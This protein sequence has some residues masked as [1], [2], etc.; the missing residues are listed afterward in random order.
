[1][2]LSVIIVNYRSWTSLATTLASLLD[3]T[4]AQPASFEII[5][6]DNDS[7]DGQLEEFQTRFP[8]VRFELAPGNH[9]FA[10]ACNIGVAA[11]SGQLLLFLN[12]DVRGRPEDLARLVAEKDAHGQYAIL[13]ACQTDSRNRPRKA[14]DSF[15]GL[16]TSVPAI[17]ALLRLLRPAAHP[18][19]R[20]AEG[21]SPVPVAL[22]WV[23]GSALLIS[24]TDLERLGGWNESFW[25]YYEDVD[26]CLRASRLG[27]RAAC[28][29]AV[30]VGHDHGGAS[31]R[32]E[33][34]SILTRT[35]VIIS[36]HVYVQN[37]FTGPYRI[38][39]HATLIIRET[40]GLALL[41]ALNLL[42]LSQLT[43]LR[44]RSGV[45]AGLLAHW[46]SALRRGSWQSPRAPA[47]D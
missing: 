24:R 26:L 41:A 14:G 35:E 40:A 12:P 43:A 32:D 34:T 6:V 3:D 1:M 39:F 20:L 4:G 21:S 42:T 13:T 7:A 2:R 9:G 29:T 37:N 45:L 22:D 19:G 44:V 8:T 5:V 23:S 17:R 30:S 11:S 25:L 38:I 36:R 27:M 31:R 15:P 18:S 33:E 16:L 10:H 28:T 46:V 47:K